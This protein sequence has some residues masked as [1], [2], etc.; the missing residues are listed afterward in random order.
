MQTRAVNEGLSRHAKEQISG[1]LFV[2]P[3]FIG[4]V[5]FTLIPV[6]ASL[7]LSFTQWNFLKG[8]G[9]VEF[10]GLANYQRLFKDPWFIQS[11]KNNLLFTLGTIP[12]LI[13]VSLIFAFIINN[14]VRGAV[15]VRTTM[16][17]PYICSTVAICTVWMVLLQP[18]Y[19]PLN[20]FLRTIG[21]ENPPNWLTSKQTSLISV[22]IIYVWQNIGYY[23]VVFIA[24]LKNIDCEVY[25]AADID[26]ANGLNKFLRI[27]VPLV[28]PTTFFLTTMGIIGSFKVFDHIEVLTQGGPGNSSSV[29]AFHIYR[30]AFQNY[31]MGYS[32]TLA[33]ALF[34][35]IFIV[36]VIQWNTQKSFTIE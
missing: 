9:A 36:T 15:G 1:M 4:F 5:I 6:I 12:V 33:W 30:T 28:S 24:G 27:T 16:F 14:Y 17:I 22:M 31:E 19:G 35:M 2:L 3:S 25:E 32:N 23:V 26:G 10:N 11:F 21:I 18:N 8:W 13:V 20:N 34:I 7:V 29:M